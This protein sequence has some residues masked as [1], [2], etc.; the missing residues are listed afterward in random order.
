MTFGFL[1][2]L[3]VLGLMASTSAIAQDAAV[4]QADDATVFGARDNIEQ[5]SLSPDGSKVAFLTPGAGQGVSLFI[6]S[7]AGGSAPVRALTTDGD[8][9]RISRC[10]WVSAN[11]LLCSLRMLVDSGTDILGYSR[12]FAVDEDGRNPKLVSNRMNARS[13]GYG[14]NGGEIV[15]LLNGDDGSV[16]V[17][18]NYVPEKEL[19]TKL[20]S[21]RDGL[22]VDQV[23]TR[24]LTTRHVE[25]PNRAAV[26]YISDG[27]GKVR[28]M[29]VMPAPNSS[30]YLGDTVRYLYRPKASDGWKELASRN[31]LSGKG[32][33]PVAVDPDLDAVYGFDDKDGRKAA[34]RV[35]LDGTGAETFL[36]EN[37]QVDVD[38]FIRIGRSQRVVG[39]S[40]A[41]EKRTA[42]YF[43]PA[44]KTLA[45]SLSKALPGN[46]AV[47]FIDSSA[48]ERKLLLRTSSDVDPGRYYIFDRDKK[49]VSE[50]LL[51]RPQLE[52]RKLAAMTPVSYKSA[53]GTV[54]PGYLSVPPGSDGKHIP[55]IVMPHGGPGA[56]D[57]WGFNWLVQFFV[58]RGF[59][60]LQPNFRGSAGYGEAWFEKNGFQ[61]WRTAVGD[62][63]DAGR[64]LVSQGIADPNKL[65]IVGWSYGGYAALQ[66]A[67]L[68]S[69]LFRAI[70]AIAPVTDLMGLRNQARR[71][72]N[73]SLVNRSLGEGP[74]IKEGSP[75]ENAA[76]IKAPVLMFHGDR[77]VNVD[78]LQSRLM[79]DRLRDAGKP[80]Q[81][82]VY[83]KLD[84]QLFDSVARADMLRKSDAFLRQSLNLDK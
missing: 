14:Q 10:D 68:D 42:V 3:S 48:D 9:E 82:V 40:F 31:I 58:A 55:A 26:E 69:A 54:I 77:D 7:A 67:A 50:I 80:S 35:A 6:A 36:L 72:T 32:F 70:I 60:V 1:A 49:S 46:P 33:M 76:R 51:A 11:R 22:G 20:A 15:D 28:I 29:G 19:G 47:N 64:W 52:G 5:A 65:A 43:D 71:F 78:I 13:L 75:A 34:V 83:P 63:N 81:L 79:A 21:S 24:T 37:A 2:R 66:S 18:R 27:R 30:G 8:P 41:T 74:H 16:L 17:S 57:E 62:V 4:T 84:H 23:D 59:A 45:M 53:D 38:D 44:L 39:A 12:L 56:R 73:F 61:S 25:S